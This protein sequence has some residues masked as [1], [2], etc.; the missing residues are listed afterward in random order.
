MLLTQFRALSMIDAAGVFLLTNILIFLSSILGC[1]AMGR[2]FPRQRLFDHW[3][4][5]S[6]IELGVAITAVLINTAV[7]V[8]G[9]LFWRADLIE[10]RDKSVWMGVIDMGL[11]VLAMDLGMYFLHRI[12]HQRWLFPLI[13]K[14]HH[15]L[16]SN[17]CKSQMDQLQSEQATSS[18]A[19]K[20]DALIGQAGDTASSRSH[21]PDQSIRFTPV[22]GQWFWGVDECIFVAIPHFTARANR[23]FDPQCRVWHLGP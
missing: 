11:M 23:V 4:P 1:W 8:V 5:F 17:N 2:L 20:L 16:M 10:L 13:H 15:H 7:S 18:D 6:P 19:E 14:F 22:R 9:W 12:A 21:Q 3:E